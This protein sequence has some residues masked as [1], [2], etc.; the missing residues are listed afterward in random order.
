M[1]HLNFSHEKADPNIILVSL[2]AAPHCIHT[3]FACCKSE[4]KV[5]VGNMFAH[6]AICVKWFN[7]SSNNVM[8]LEERRAMA[9][10]LQRLT[11]CRENEMA[12][13]GQEEC[14]AIFYKMTVFSLAHN[15]A[16][17]IKN[18]NPE[19]QKGYFWALF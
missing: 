15:V 18:K 5:I 19:T 12:G 3:L 9:L 16:E 10:L 17:V 11:H 7:Y 1:V 4:L 8:E 13:K 14:K 6:G 2:V